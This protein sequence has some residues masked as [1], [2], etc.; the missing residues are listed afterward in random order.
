MAAI[1]WEVVRVILGNCDIAIYSKKY[2]YLILVPVSATEFLKPLNFLGAESHRGVFC[3]VNE[4]MFGN[5][6]RM[7]SGC[8][9]NQPVD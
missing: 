2:I 5:H 8:Q 4:V 3:Y 6:L 1:I 9:G 7:G